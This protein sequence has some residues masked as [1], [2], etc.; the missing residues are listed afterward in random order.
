MGL[1]SFGYSS[2]VIAINLHCFNLSINF[3]N[4][5]GCNTENKP[6]K[7]GQTKNEVKRLKAIVIWG[8]IKQSQTIW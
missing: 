6:W 3:Y 1:F 8:E 4:Y 2:K 7:N 5:M